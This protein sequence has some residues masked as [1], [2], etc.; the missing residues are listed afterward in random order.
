MIGHHFHLD[1]R[2]PPLLHNLDNQGLESRVDP[3]NQDFA[4]VLGAKHNVIMTIVND[5][6]VALNYC[7]HAQSIA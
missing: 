3:I 4:P 5:I 1:K 7:L 2:L 6:L